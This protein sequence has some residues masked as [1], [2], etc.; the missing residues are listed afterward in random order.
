MVLQDI[1]RPPFYFLVCIILLSAGNHFKQH[2]EYSQRS[3]RDSISDSGTSRNSISFPFEI[4]V[5]EIKGQASSEV[6]G[7][8]AYLCDKAFSTL[9]YIEIKFRFRSAVN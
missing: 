1:L 4:Y 8:F 7:Y 6:D 5:N 2:M 3:F 9:A